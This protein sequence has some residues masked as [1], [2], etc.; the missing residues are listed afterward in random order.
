[1]DDTER[2]I[3]KVRERIAAA[4]VRSGRPADAVELLAVSKTRTVGVVQ[5][6]VDAGVLAL[7]E[8]RVQEAAEKIPQIRG[9]PVWHLIGGLQSN[10]TARAAELFD[11]IH[12]VDRTKL[13]AR[14]GAAAAASARTI[15]IYVQVEFTRS[16]VAEAEL[17]PRAREVARAV[18]EA[19][20]LE[21][22]G[23]MTLPPYDPDPEAARPWFV[24]LRTIQEGLARHG[25][26]APGLS[27]GMSNDFEVAIEEG[28][29]IVRVGTTIFG[30]RPQ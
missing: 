28:A 20:N 16:G 17:E 21:L 10:K 7:G 18:T 23:L 6:A 25:I 30:P 13:V 27:M 2:R 26:A 1:M 8:N 29:T 19:P 15:Q 5:S 24:R 12:S 11:V 4:A 22:A 3:A 9:N 14:L